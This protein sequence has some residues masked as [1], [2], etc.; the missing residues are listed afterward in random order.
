MTGTEKRKCPRI[1]V[2][3]PITAFVGEKV[4]EGETRNIT[5]FGVF[6]R[7]SDPMVLNET[8]RLFIKPPAHKPISVSGQVRWSDVYTREGKRRAFGMG[9]AF[10]EISDDDRHLIDRLIRDLPP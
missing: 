6:M 10:V 4:I 8:Y 3:W 7:S 2:K 1:K 5:N 9:F